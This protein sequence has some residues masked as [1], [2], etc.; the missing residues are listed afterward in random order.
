MGMNI[1]NQETCRLAA[2]V[3][4]LTGETLTRAVTE[5]LRIRLEDLRRAEDK[6]RLLADV[7]VISGFFMTELKDPG[8][9]WDS[10]SAQAELYDETGLPK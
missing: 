8:K 7:R 4:A 1:K 2:E 5:A 9:N 6:E 3:A 10:L